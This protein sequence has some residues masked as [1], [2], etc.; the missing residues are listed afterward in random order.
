[1][2]KK[3]DFMIYGYARVSTKKQAKDGNGLEE[4]K[5]A[6]QAAGCNMV[7][8]E[9]YTGKSTPRPRLNSLVKL[10]KSNDTLMVTKL[11]RLA[12][13]VT[14][15]SKL[16]QSLLERGIKVHI[17]NMG[18]VDNTAIGRVILN[19]LLA[20][21]EFERDMIIERTQAGRAIARTKKDY[22]EGRPPLNPDRV[23]HAVDLIVEHHISYTEVERKTGISRSSLLRYVRKRKLENKN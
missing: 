15:G 16:I 5:I 10:L 13:T 12:R 2:F 9:E 7:I 8:E 3:G 22:K 18:L 11:D 21:A 23:N 1:M 14:D 4:Q 20:F 17:L 6:L 19:V